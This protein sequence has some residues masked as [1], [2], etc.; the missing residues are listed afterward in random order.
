VRGLLDSTRV[1]DDN[2]LEV[3]VGAALPAA[4]ELATNA[5]KTVDGDAALLGGDSDLAGSTGAGL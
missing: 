5:A 1:V 2:N 4:E 3:G